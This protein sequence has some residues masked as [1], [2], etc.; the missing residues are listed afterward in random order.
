MH[1][2]SSYDEAFALLKDEKNPASVEEGLSLLKNI[3]AEN[4]NDAKAWFEYAGGFD[5][6]GREAE[7]KPLYEKALAF[8]IESLPAADRPRIF[9]Q[10]GSTLRNLNEFAESKRVL[11]MGIHAYPDF[12][13]L[14][15]FLGLTEHSLGNAK[16]AAKLFLEASL[17]KA[18]DDS[19]R[20]Y[21]RALRH[22]LSIL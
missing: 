7:A 10:L 18:G 2:K 11:Q 3:V 6:L 8:G 16:I 1:P 5:F 14:K 22:Y 21:E 12:A 9:L 13:A 4:P 15:A 17:A 20:D 19:M